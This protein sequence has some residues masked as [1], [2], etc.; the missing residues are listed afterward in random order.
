MNVIVEMLYYN[1]YVRNILIITYI[2]FSRSSYD[3]KRER[4]T[5]YGSILLEWAGKSSLSFC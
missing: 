1:I 4:M 2:K 3:L 5:E